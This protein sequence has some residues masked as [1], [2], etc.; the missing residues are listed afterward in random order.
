[1]KRIDKAKIKTIIWAVQEYEKVYKN[2]P[3]PTW[4]QVHF[5]DTAF[6]QLVNVVENTLGEKLCN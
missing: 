6:W 4:N 3:I 5:Y 1:M 2:A